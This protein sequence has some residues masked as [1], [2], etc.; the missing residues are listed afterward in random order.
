MSNSTKTTTNTE[1]AILSNQ[2]QIICVALLSRAITLLSTQRSLTSLFAQFLVHSTMSIVFPLLYSMH[3]IFSLL[4]S[5]YERQA[6]SMS[7]VFAL[8]FIVAVAEQGRTS[9]NRESKTI[10]GLD[11][12]WCKHPNIHL[13]LW[14]K[15]TRPQTTPLNIAA[16]FKH[17]IFSILW[18]GARTPNSCHSGANSPDAGQH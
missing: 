5:I 8:S 9:P 2:I 11:A 13:S 7:R 6:T 3:Y 10:S 12:D 18:I 4:K 1:T 15:L 16:T 14:C 17:L